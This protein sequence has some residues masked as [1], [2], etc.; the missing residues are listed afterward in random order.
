MTTSDQGNRGA[1]ST[2]ADQIGKVF[3]V[4]GQDVRQC[5][6]CDGTF[7]RQASREHAEMT[8]RL[9]VGRTGGGDLPCGARR[10]ASA[11]AKLRQIKQQLRERMHDPVLQTGQWLQSIVQ[12]YFNYYAVRCGDGGLLRSPVERLSPK[13]TCSLC[14]RNRQ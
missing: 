4:V 1:A 7:M 8:C 12:G 2:S 6:I 11:R 13:L 5:L 9:P 10:S 14:D 3:V